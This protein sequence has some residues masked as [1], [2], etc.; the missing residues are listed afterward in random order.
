MM[1]L[2]DFVLCKVSDVICFL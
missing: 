1:I 2:S